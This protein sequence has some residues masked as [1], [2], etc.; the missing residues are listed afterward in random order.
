MRRG[1]DRSAVAVRN[2]LKDCSAA[3]RHRPVN[4]LP[5]YLDNQ[6]DLTSCNDESLADAVSQCAKRVYNAGQA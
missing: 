5:S 2:G 6:L 3:R 1:D 4:L